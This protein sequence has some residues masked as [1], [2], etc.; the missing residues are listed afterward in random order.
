MRRTTPLAPAIA[1]S[2][3]A[4]PAATQVDDTFVSHIVPEGSGGCSD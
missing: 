1:I 4:V 2:L 3:G